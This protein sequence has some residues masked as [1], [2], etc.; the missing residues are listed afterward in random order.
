MNKNCECFSLTFLSTYTPSS[1]AP[2]SF[3]L[4]FLCSGRPRGAHLDSGSCRAHL[5]CL[6]SVSGHS[7]PVFLSSVS[8]DTTVSFML[9]VL[10]N[11]FIWVYKSVPWYFILAGGGS[12]LTCL[13]MLSFLFK[14]DF[15]KLKNVG[16]FENIKLQL[17]LG[18]STYVDQHIP[19]QPFII[20]LFLSVSLD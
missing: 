14:V 6:Q 3:Q 19:C 20:R 11:C 13:T 10:E 17:H 8:L 15:K 4:C 16:I 7:C 12:F 9:S 5:I 18:K 1:A 2:L